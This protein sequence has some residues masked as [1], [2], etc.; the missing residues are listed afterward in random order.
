MGQWES[1]EVKGCSGPT[2]RVRES[3]IGGLLS[4]GVIGDGKVSKW[5]WIRWR[6]KEVADKRKQQ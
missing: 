3:T 1:A 5:R 6:K 2:V 4:V